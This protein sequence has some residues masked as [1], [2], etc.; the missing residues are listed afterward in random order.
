MTVSVTG[1]QNSLGGLAGQIMF[2]LPPSFTNVLQSCQS[3][4]RKSEEIRG[5]QSLVVCSRTDNFYVAVQITIAYLAPQS[6]RLHR[7]LPYTALP[8]KE[9]KPFS[10]ACLA[11]FV[12]Q[13][14]AALIACS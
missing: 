1:L 5:K 6:V 7:L 13:I 12:S 2:F 10:V 14:S 8:Y 4:Q 3:S 9:R 11:K